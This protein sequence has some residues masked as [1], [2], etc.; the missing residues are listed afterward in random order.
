MALVLETKQ[1]LLTA[2]QTIENARAVIKRT[3]RVDKTQ[4]EM[5]IKCSCQC[6]FVVKGLLLDES[7]CMIHYY[8]M[9]YVNRTGNLCHGTEFGGQRTGLSGRLSQGTKDWILAS[10]RSGKS[11]AQVMADHKAEVLRCARLNLPV[12]RDTF[13]M[14]SDVY[15]I[16]SVIAT[17]LWQLDPRNAVS[18]RM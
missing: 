5:S 18:V 1:R 14:P 16:A 2:Q 11:P 15:N 12:T 7:L 6:C 8:C 10:L 4:G 17:K 9:E 13:I 3:T